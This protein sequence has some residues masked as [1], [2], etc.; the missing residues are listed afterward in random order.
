[1]FAVV[2]VETV[3]A[4]GVVVAADGLVAA[5][6]IAAVPTPSTSTAPV[7]A[8]QRRARIVVDVIMVDLLRRRCLG[9]EVRTTLAGPCKHSI[10]PA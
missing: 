7:V 1:V 6:A 5:F 4:A 8:T 10:E 9:V 2:A 3:E